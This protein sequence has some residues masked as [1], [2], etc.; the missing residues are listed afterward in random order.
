MKTLHLN[1]KESAYWRQLTDGILDG[2]SKDTIIDSMARLKLHRVVVYG[3]NT[4]T[5]HALRIALGESF[6]SYVNEETLGICADLEFDAIIVGTSPRHYPV[7]SQRL[8]NMLGEKDFILITCFNESKIDICNEDHK[9][10]WADFDEFAVARWSHWDKLLPLAA[11]LYGRPVNPAV[12]DLKDYQDLLVLAFIRDNLPTGARLLEIGGGNSRVLAHLARTHDCWNI[13]K[14][15]GVGNGPLEA[16]N[17]GYTVVKD[18]I[19]NFNPMLADNSFDLVFSI[20]ALEHVPDAD[21]AGLDR[22]LEDM[23]RVLKPG[24]L[25]IHCL[26]IVL[27]QERVWMNRILPRIYENRNTLHPWT[28]ANSLLTDPDIYCMTKESYQRFWEPICGTPYETFGKASS[29]NV[30]WRK[31]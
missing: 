4:K 28:P 17:A 14:F 30:L 22:V 8:R 31:P 29:S 7:V 12:C 25:S 1:I 26:D 2:Q 13:D 5:G 16:R 21:T 11:M 9:A 27:S 19:G 23:D 3:E 6:V 18:Y 15:E 10:R 24:G 20:S